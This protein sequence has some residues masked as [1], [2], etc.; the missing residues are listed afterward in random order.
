MTLHNFSSFSALRT[1]E[2]HADRL[3]ALY[4]LKEFIEFQCKSDHPL[5]K[6]REHYKHIYKDLKSEFVSKMYRCIQ[7]HLVKHKE[8]GR[9]LGWIGNWEMI[10]YH[11][12][13]QHP[14]TRL[15]LMIFPINNQG[16]PLMRHGGL[17]DLT[18]LEFYDPNNYDNQFSDEHLKVTSEFTSKGKKQFVL[19]DID[20]VKITKKD[21][22]VKALIASL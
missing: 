11:L 22:R 12:E 15:E 5:T 6:N 14:K 2:K 20:G 9:V 1:I 8:T 3:C 18:D 17:Y 13:G 21:P 4:E 19:V 10:T 7:G 16:R